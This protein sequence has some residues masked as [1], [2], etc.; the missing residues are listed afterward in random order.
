MNCF[1]NTV[2]KLKVKADAVLCLLVMHFVE[3]PFKVFEGRWQFDALAANACKV[4]L[5][6]EFEFA[7]RV[8]GMALGSRFEKNANRQVDALC[9]RAEVIYARQV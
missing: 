8:L 1:Y 9:E 5:H 2:D 4:S 3:G 7:S 6:L